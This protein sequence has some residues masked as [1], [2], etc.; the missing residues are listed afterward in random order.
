MKR[1][2]MMAMALM[3]MLSVCSGAYALEY[4]DTITVEGET[5]TVA[6]AMD[7]RQYYKLETFNLEAVKV[8][9]AVNN[10]CGDQAMDERALWGNW[11]ECVYWREQ[12]AKAGNSFAMY[13]LWEAYWDVDDA[14]AV[15]KAI[16]YLKQAA[17]LGMQHA[18]FELAKGYL[19]GEIGD[20]WDTIEFEKDEEKGRE[21]LI[22]AAES[23]VLE[24]MWMLAQ[25]YERGFY[26]LPVDIQKAV[27]WYTQTRERGMPM[28]YEYVRAIEDFAALCEREESIENHD[29]MAFELYMEANNHPMSDGCFFGVWDHKLAA[30]YAEGRGTEQDVDKAWEILLEMRENYEGNNANWLYV[31]GMMY[32][33]GYGVEKDMEIAERCYEKARQIEYEMDSME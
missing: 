22:S 15:E 32:E 27:D 20:R 7:L 10:A 16:G 14:E 33:N 18:C 9:E 6:Y 17:E 3:V 29:E 30:M 24:A 11:E 12:A 31:V 4:T 23:G 13:L 28:L 1:M 19:W 2:M 8:M 26:G 25:A 21:L 5:M